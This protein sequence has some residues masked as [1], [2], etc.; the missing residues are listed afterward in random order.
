MTRAESVDVDAV[1]EAEAW[2]IAVQLPG[3]AWSNVMRETYP[4]PE[5]RRRL[6]AVEDAG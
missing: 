3:S 1:D 4:L 5:H 2:D 6:E